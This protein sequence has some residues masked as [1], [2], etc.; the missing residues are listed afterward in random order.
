MIYCPLYS[1]GA[2]VRFDDT[3]IV[4][5]IVGIEANLKV[6]KGN[7]FSYKTH[8]LVSTEDGSKRKIHEVNIREVKEAL[9]EFEKGMNK[10][11]AD[12]LLLSRHLDPEGIDASIKELLNENV[13]GGKN[14]GK[15]HE[16]L[17]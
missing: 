1:V 14:N 2:K 17:L 12:S 10:F 11:L 7:K 15:Q 8:Y 5:E 16:G 3:D 9:T 4:G 13:T 6:E